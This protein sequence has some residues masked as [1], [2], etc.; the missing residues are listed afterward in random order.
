MTQSNPATTA[1]SAQAATSGIALNGH[2]L[3][4][5]LSFLAPDNTTDQLDGDLVIE[6]H[7]AGPDY[8]IAGLYAYHSDCPEEGAILLEGIPEGW[9]PCS[10]EMLS[11]GV[12]CATAPRIAGA[13]GSGVSHYHPL[14]Q[15]ANEPTDGQLFAFGCD[16]GFPMAMQT[17]HPV[18]GPVFW[19]YDSLK[20][21]NYPTAREAMVAEFMKNQ[22]PAP[23]ASSAAVA[24][25]PESEDLL[26]IARQTG[27]RGFI[28]GVNATDTREMLARFVAE[29]PVTKDAQRLEHFFATAQQITTD[30]ATSPAAALSRLKDAISM[31]MAQRNGHVQEGC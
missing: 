12:C 16:Y 23:V 19:T 6:L 7:H 11:A 3:R 25:K 18:E 24:V 14:P 30:E 13:P 1:P 4:E 26:Y 21:D 5:A 29:L 8:P 31:T 28:H 9:A 22:S 17:I 15:N 2:Q 27:L 10:P 20:G